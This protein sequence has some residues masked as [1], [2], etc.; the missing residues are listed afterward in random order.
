MAP[1]SE[2]CQCEQEER[3]EQAHQA[4]HLAKNIGK[5]MDDIDYWFKAVYQLAISVSIVFEFV[6]FDFE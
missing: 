5:Y 3:A 6:R 2:Q 4:D 1:N